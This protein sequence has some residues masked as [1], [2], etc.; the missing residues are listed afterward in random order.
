MPHFKTPVAKYMSSPV[1]SIHPDASIDDAYSIL[2][3]YKFSGLAVVDG[4]HRLVGVL[5]RT[6]L[7]HLGRVTALGKGRRSPLIDLPQKSVREVMKTEIV[8]IAP[9]ASLRDAAGLMVEHHIHRVFIEENHKL[10]GVISTK[11]LM[12]AIAESR[13]H[14]PISEVMST[15]IQTI[16][17][18]S[19]I[20]V[21]ADKLDEAHI[22]GLV[23]LDEDEMPVGVFTQAEALQAKSFP[24]TTLV[25]DLM[26]YAMICMNVKTPMHRAAA[27]ASATS[28]R[29]IIA[30]EDRHIW[31]VLTGIDFARAVVTG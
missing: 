10:K 7:L 11:D 22:S 27:Q 29:R 9:E 21:A 31:G 8:R 20:A 15:P 1:R 16:S 30:V 26:N 17:S 3:E 23:V 25:E 18:M 2:R 13:M 12:N 24:P 19:T 4:H 5:S 28:A 6:D 14:R